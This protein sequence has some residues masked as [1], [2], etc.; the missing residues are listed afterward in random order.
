MP[1][2]ETIMIWKFESAP[3]EIRSLHGAGEVPEWIV[4]VP[5]SVYG[6]DLEEAFHQRSGM[7][8]QYR[9]AEGEIVFMGAAPI[10][11]VLESLREIRHIPAS[12][13]R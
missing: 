11:D 5:P 6:A 13:Q 7:I 9:T 8:A 2:T 4:L 3:A 10:A 12:P 1:S